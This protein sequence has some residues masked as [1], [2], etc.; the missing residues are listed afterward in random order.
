MV[1]SIEGLDV[2]MLMSRTFLG[3]AANTLTS[4]S[5]RS[6]VRGFVELEKCVLEYKTFVIILY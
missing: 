5:M 3:V 6:K 4:K 2:L 1:N